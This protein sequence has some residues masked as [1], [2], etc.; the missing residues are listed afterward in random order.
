MRLHPTDAARGP[1]VPVVG[2]SGWNRLLDDGDE[3]LALADVSERDTSGF[4][5]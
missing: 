5:A 4:S 3:D 1:V 2:R